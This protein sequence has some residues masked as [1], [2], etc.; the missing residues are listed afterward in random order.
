M[1]ATASLCSTTLQSQ[2]SGFGGGLKLRRSYLSPPN[3][4]TSTRYLSYLFF[5]FNLLFL[6]LFLAFCLMAIRLLVT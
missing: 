1:S 4:L 5:S 6:F 3:S 2:I